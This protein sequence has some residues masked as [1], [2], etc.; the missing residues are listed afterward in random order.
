[1]GEAADSLQGGVLS[2][3]EKLE[4]RA[5]QAALKQG[6]KRRH[7]EKV[8]RMKARI[9]ELRRQRDEL[10]TKLDVCRSELIGA[11]DSTK[12]NSQA[13]QATEIGQQALLEWKME[14][15][16]GLLRV[17]RLTGFSAKLTKRG[18]CLCIT[19]AFDGTYL[20]SYYLDLLIQQPVQ[21]Q[22]HSVP[23][24]IPLEQIACKHLQMDIKRFLTELSDHL[25][26]YAR[27]K[28]QAD[29]LQEHFAAFL[30]GRLLG[31]PLCNLLEFTYSVT[32][33]DRS[34]PFTAKLTYGD[35][36]SDRPTDITVK[37]KEDAPASLAEMAA[38]HLALFHEKPLHEVFSSITASAE[39]L[40]QSI[41]L[42]LPAPSTAVPPGGHRIPTEA[43]AV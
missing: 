17:F 4:A 41:A 2:H 36:V 30:E 23:A 22:Q 16:K 31:N 40:S 24:F 10:R 11:K 14:N 19:T 7:E 8:A 18:A 33:E 5:N 38:V 25:N 32:R 21:I 29:Q 34:F 6:E 27:R 28:F 1:M 20:D 37:C 39:N 12:S 26:A 42:E 3:L 43:A 9:R 35:P 13:P 15:V